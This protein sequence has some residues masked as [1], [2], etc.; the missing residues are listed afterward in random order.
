MIDAAER[1]VAERG[2][3]ALTLRDVQSS[4]GQSNKSAAKYH[5][6]S[7]EGLLDAVIEARMSPV[8]GRRQEMLD[9]L[10]AQPERPRVRQAVEALIQPL[11][12]ET[13][14][15]TESRYARFLVQ[16][17]HDPG[18]AD[19]IQH[20]MSAASF[21]RVREL[22]TELAPVPRDVAE[23]RVVNIINLNLVTLARWERH[24]RSLQQTAAII[25]DLVTTCVAVLETPVTA[26]LDTEGHIT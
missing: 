25:S 23:W 4:A 24:D 16:A 6:G 1:I 15:R 17:T 7:R 26:T 2:L 14:G 8:N 22:L 21:R 18:L 10:A 13:L 11:A 3:A 19:S 5:F 9:A 12:A 20:H